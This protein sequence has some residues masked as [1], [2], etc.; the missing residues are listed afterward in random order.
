M[1]QT[2]RRREEARLRTARRRSGDRLTEGQA[3]SGRGSNQERICL[4][5]RKRSFLK[6]T[7]VQSRTKFLNGVTDGEARKPRSTGAKRESLAEPEERSDKVGLSHRSEAT[8][9]ARMPEQR[10]AGQLILLMHHW[11]PCLKLRSAI[12]IVLST[13]VAKDANHRF[14]S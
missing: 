9:G 12:L 8:S 7:E 5:I 6:P 2:A 13:V 1:A 11:R 3:A 10:R 4:A 14:Q